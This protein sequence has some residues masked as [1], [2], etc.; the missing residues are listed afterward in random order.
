M[1]RNLSGSGFDAMTLASARIIS[2]LSGILSTMVLSRFLD[3][4]SYG[5]YSQALLII[6]LV[7]SFTIIGLGDACNYF[8]NKERLLITKKNY[9]NTIILIECVVGSFAGLLIIVTNNLICNY[10]SNDN[11]KYILILIAFCPMLENIL[12]IYQVIFVSIGKA[13]IIAIRNLIITVI[14]LIAVLI[15]AYWAKKIEYIFVAFLVMDIAQVIYFYIILRQNKFEMHPRN[16]SGNMVKP[17]LQYSIPMALATITKTLSKDMDKLFISSVMDTEHFAVYSNCAKELP[18]DFIVTSMLTVLIPFFT[19]YYAEKQWENGV[20]LICDYIKFGYLTTG[21]LI[22]ATLICSTEVISFL[23]S[24]KY[25][26]GKWIFIIYLIVD[27]LRFLDLSVVVNSAGLTK[28]IMIYNLLSLGINFILNIIFY[29]IWGWYGPAIAT[30][31]SVLIKNIMVIREALRLYKKKFKDIINIKDI[32][33]FYFIEII[34]GIMLVAFKSQLKEA[35]INYIIEMLIIMGLFICISFV[36]N[37]KELISIFN[38]LN[39]LKSNF[40]KI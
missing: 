11:L 8:F 26:D 3:K 7:S 9:I 30:V 2:L 31:V 12:L 14:K 35:G 19:Y 1:K 18:F 23:Y 24:D 21:I 13:K 17:I 28:K 5:T 6:S 32:V 38:R 4:T 22:G 15:T 29:L 33:K 36:I 39:S 37:R 40:N 20:K 27:L 25:I 16:F 10:Y 34:L